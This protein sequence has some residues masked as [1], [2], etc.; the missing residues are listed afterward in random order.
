[1]YTTRRISMLNIDIYIYVY[2]YMCNWSVPGAD[3]LTGKVI[4]VPLVE[5]QSEF[6]RRPIAHTC[7][8]VLEI[9]TTYVSYV[10][11]RN[12]VMSV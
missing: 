11:L 9:P 6:Q 5:P 4:S 1:M 8:C 10:E 7:G 2:I 3:V 12:D